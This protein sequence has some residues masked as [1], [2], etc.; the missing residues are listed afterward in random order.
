MRFQGEMTN[1]GVGSLIVWASL[2]ENI[3]RG[4]I[5]PVGGEENRPRTGNPESESP[6]VLE[7]LAV[8]TPVLGCGF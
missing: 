2:D 6:L 5:S 7:L 8:N 4:C 3:S 1:S